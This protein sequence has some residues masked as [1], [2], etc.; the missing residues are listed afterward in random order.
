MKLHFVTKNTNEQKIA[1]F[2]TAVQT[3]FPHAGR[4]IV[5][6]KNEFDARPLRREEIER[7]AHENA[8]RLLSEIRNNYP[9]EKGVFVIMIQKGTNLMDDENNCLL[10]CSVAIHSIDTT[11][12]LFICSDEE[13]NIPP[14]MRTLVHSGMELY[15]A[16]QT[17]LG[18]AFQNGKGSPF[19]IQTGRSEINWIRFTIEK[20]LG[21]LK[22]KLNIA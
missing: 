3:L 6:F 5:L 13:V 2:D 16:W 15:Q 14:Q 20:A 19:E 11:I 1:A 17:V 7:A 18:D 12:E 9:N 4:S 21:E 22:K 10:L 8:R